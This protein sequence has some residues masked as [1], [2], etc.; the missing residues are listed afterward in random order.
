MNWSIPDV[1]RINDF[2]IEVTLTVQQYSDQNRNPL[3]WWSKY[4]FPRFK[5]VL[6]NEAE[7]RPEDL[8]LQ[9]FI[10]KRCR[11]Y[12][13]EWADEAL[14][15]VGII[16]VNRYLLTVYNKANRKE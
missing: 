13:E 4:D 6:L 11:D 12:F 7:S 14:N 5:E 3:W 2:K 16:D 8:P 15:E 9:T 10:L 1:L